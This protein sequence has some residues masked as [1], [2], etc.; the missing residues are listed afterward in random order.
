M[1]TPDGPSID[2][3]RDFDALGT[4]LQQ[5]EVVLWMGQP[6]DAYRARMFI[7]ACCLG[8]FLV[9]ALILIRFWVNDSAP[10]IWPVLLLLAILSGMFAQLGLGGGQ[11]QRR[12]SYVLTDRR[13][14]RFQGGSHSEVR[15]NQLTNVSFREHGDGIGTIFCIPTGVGEWPKR[16]RHGRPRSM[17]RLIGDVRHVHALLLDAMS[18]VHP[19][20]PTWQDPAGRNQYLARKS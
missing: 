1:P 12:I 4:M 7:S 16:N 6:Y 5:G 9:L 3:A 10:N 13:A 14:L 15:L 18:R 11:A 19:P 2:Y 20:P 8:V 17:F